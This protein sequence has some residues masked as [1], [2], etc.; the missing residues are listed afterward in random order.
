MPLMNMCGV[1]SHRAI[2]TASGFGLAIALPATLGFIVS[3]WGAAGRPAFSIG[4]VNVLGVVVIAA[5]AFLTIPLG[6]KLAHGMSQKKL[7]MVFGICLLLVAANM[8]R[9]ALF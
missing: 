1:P 7:K 3:G 8:A 6:A 4:Y 2:G 5:V 9:K